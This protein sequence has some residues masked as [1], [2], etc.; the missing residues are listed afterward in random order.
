MQLHQLVVRSTED[1]SDLALQP[2]GGGLTATMH[3]RQ[4]HPSEVE[5]TDVA[6][7]IR[8]ISDLPDRLPIGSRGG[9]L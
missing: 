1:E 9:V 5:E 4:M 6:L 8:R 3:L 7:A 2:N